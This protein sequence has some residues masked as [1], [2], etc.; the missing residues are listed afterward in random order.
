MRLLASPVSKTSLTFQGTAIFK[1]VG[2]QLH[3]HH[4]LLLWVQDTGSNYC[5]STGSDAK[6]KWMFFQAV[7]D[8]SGSLLYFLIIYFPDC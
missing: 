1:E 5:I 8:D 7:F 4:K 2:L 6:K 3:V